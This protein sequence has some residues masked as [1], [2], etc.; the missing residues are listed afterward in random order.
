VIEPIYLRDEGDVG[1]ADEIPIAGIDVFGLKATS[2]VLLMG[3][4][5]TLE[6][7]I[8][9]AHY[10]IS[11]MLPRVWMTVEG[12]IEVAHSALAGLRHVVLHDGA[13]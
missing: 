6:T 8:L 11:A 5:Y 7:P 3:G 9:G 10:S 13:E 1:L 4:F 12:E 2:D